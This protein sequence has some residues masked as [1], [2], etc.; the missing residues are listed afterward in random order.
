MTPLVLAGKWNLGRVTFNQMDWIAT[1]VLILKKWNSISC[2]IRD[3]WSYSGDSQKT[4]QRVILLR[5]KASAKISEN[6]FRGLLVWKAC[7][8]V[9]HSFTKRQHSYCAGK[10]SALCSRRLVDIL[11]DLSQVMFLLWP[12]VSQNLQGEGACH[13]RCL[14]LK[15]LLW[16]AISLAQQYIMWVGKFSD[17]YEG[18]DLDWWIITTQTSFRRRFPKASMTDFRE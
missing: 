10:E 17:G 2:S 12:I 14:G 18:L 11:R 3:N 1:G 5:G 16:S 15:M 13:F 9:T 7:R 6:Y 8:E 4:L